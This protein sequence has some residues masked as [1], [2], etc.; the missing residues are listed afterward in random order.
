M[1]NLF[2]L[3][4]SFQTVILMVSLFNLISRPWIERENLRIGNT[5]FDKEPLPDVLIPVRNEETRLNPL[6]ASLTKGAAG[7]NK[8]I[9]YDDHSTDKTASIIRNSMEQVSKI[10]LIE[11]RPLPGGWNGKTYACHQ[12]AKQSRAESMLFVDADVMISSD[13]SFILSKVLWRDKLSLV[14]VFPYQEMKSIGERVTV[15]LMHWILLSLL[16]LRMVF[17]LKHDSIA[18]AN[19]QVMLFNAE[20]YRRNGWH[21]LVRSEVVEDI[22]IARLVKRK[23]YRM[24]V[25]VSHGAVRCRMYTS[26]MEAVKGFSKNIHQ[27]F[28]GSRLLAFGY[29][30]LFGI[31]PIVILPFIDLWQGLVL[32]SFIILNRVSTSIIA[33]QNILGNLFLHPVQM[34]VMIHILIIN[35]REKTKKK[36]QWKGRDIDLG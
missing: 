18:A 31:V 24:R 34:G 35:L 11:G 21:S 28:G 1:N 3:L 32:G 36:I 6:L 15:P 13:L 9:F 26:Y 8:I 16:P 14:S 20:V 4:L 25:M 5:D 33:G 19:G 10:E 27:F 29:V 12:L 23:G 2:I 22:K 17:S 30:L 7:F